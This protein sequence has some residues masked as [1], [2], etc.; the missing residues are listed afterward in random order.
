MKKLHIAIVALLLGL[1]AVLG[2]A[3]LSRTTSLGAATTR[4]RDAA[5]AARARQLDAI[6]ASLRKQLAQKPLATLRS[7]PA[8]APAPRVVYHRPPPIVVT[9]HSPHGEHERDEGHDD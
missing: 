3:A 9:T 8:T 6:A 5:I 1:A 4:A 7:A 2:T